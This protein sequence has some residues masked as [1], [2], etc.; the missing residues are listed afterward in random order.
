M[1]SAG[2]SL[3]RVLHLFVRKGVLVM[4][5]E[6]KGFDDVLEQAIEVGVEDVQEQGDDEI[7]VSEIHIMKANTLEVVIEP[8][9]LS[10]KARTFRDFGYEILEADT[11]W[12]SLPEAEIRVESSSQPALK[13][14]KVME[15]LN[16]EEDVT[17]IYSN[18]VST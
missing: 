1:S 4:K 13:L 6:G 7:K 8:D 2:G 15:A 17:G 3:S 14:A 11:I 12:L 16:E 18:V 10:S 5:I 9:Q